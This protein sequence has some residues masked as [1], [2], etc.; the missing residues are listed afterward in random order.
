MKKNKDQNINKTK[1]EIK[2]NKNL[3]NKIFIILCFIIYMITIIMISSFH[4][5]WEDE[6]QAWLIARDLDFLQ[7]IE[8]MKYEGHSFMWHYLLAFFAKSG[9]P[10]IF[11]NILMFVFAGAICLLILIKAPF[12][13]ITKI[14]ILFSSVFLYYMPIILR[15]Y[16]IIPLMLIILSILNEKPEKYPIAYGVCIAIL[17]NTHIIVLG[18]ATIIYMFY[19]KEELLDKFY[20]NSKKQ[21]YKLI[22]GAIIAFLGILLVVIMAIMGYIFSIAATHGTDQIISVLYRA[23]DFGKNLSK[24]FIG[25]NKNTSVIILLEVLL[26]LSLIIKAFRVNK[27][28]GIIFLVGLM[29]YLYVQLAIFG[30]YTDQRTALIYVFILFLSWNMASASEHKNK[31]T[32]FEILLIIITILSLPNTINVIYQDIKYPYNDSKAV[33]DYI[34]KNIEEGSIFI[35]VNWDSISSTEV[36]LSGKDYKFYDATDCKF[37]TYATWNK[38]LDKKGEDYLENAINKLSEESNEK[39]YV[40]NLISEDSDIMDLSS[41]KKSQ[42]RLKLIYSTSGKSLAR[43]AYL[44][45]IIK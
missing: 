34:N 10:Y 22:I 9:L 6:A 18:F 13:N 17:S 8:Q 45:E 40:L 33:A 23:V 37:M 7:I 31:M 44:Y 12:K 1:N 16:I 26:F 11:T 25:L 21:N 3:V 14:L 32:F 19:L 43:K 42:D 5:A 15:P 24:V 30:I 41:F 28:Q 27:K 36:Y 20:T 35:T 38:F 39:L 29:F 2:H 4:E